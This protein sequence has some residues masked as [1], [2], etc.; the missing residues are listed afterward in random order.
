MQVSHLGNDDAFNNAIAQCHGDLAL[1][2]VNTWVTIG[3]TA[4]FFLLSIVE[5]VFLLRKPTVVRAPAV[6]LISKL[7]T[8]TL[9]AASVIALL[10]LD[11]T[12]Q[13]R[14]TQCSLTLEVLNVLAA[15]SA[16]ILSI[17]AH[18]K[19]HRPPTVL[20]SF[21]FVLLIANVARC[22]ELWLAVRDKPDHTYAAVFATSTVIQL[23][24]LVVNAKLHAGWMDWQ[25]NIHSP[26]ETS[27]IFSLGLY[28]W[29]NQLL[30]KGYKNIL[31]LDDLYPLD[32]TIAANPDGKGIGIRSD[33][34]SKH[35]DWDI[36]MWVVKPLIKPLVLP[37]FPRLCL[38]AFNFCQPFYIQSLLDFITAGSEGS[39]TK[40]SGLI[41]AAIL[42]YTGI[43]VSTSLY[44]Y[45]QERAQSIMRAY[46]VTAIYQKTREI[47][48]TG[49]K[50]AVTLMSTDVDRIYTGM[51]NMHE[52]WVNLIQ[53]ALAC[54]LLQRQLGLAFLAPL[55]LVALSFASSFAL[56]KYAIKYQR[57][58][59]HYIEKR[60]SVTSSVLSHI[61][62]YRISGLITPVRD[63]VQAKRVEEIHHGAKSRSLIASSATLS[64]IPQIVAP[65]V[66][67]S[68]GPRVISNANAYTALSYLSLLTS[69]LM[70]TLQS[71]PIT[72]ACFAC[73]KRIHEFLAI[74]PRLDPRLSDSR[75]LVLDNIT[76]DSMQE[77]PQEAII[78]VRAGQF[79]WNA[80][81]PVLKNI[82]FTLAQSSFMFITGPVAAGKSTLCKA[83]L[84]EVPH[85]KGHILL[86][87]AANKV[88]FC[89]Q[90]PFLV[91]GSVMENITGFSSFDELRYK[92]VIHATLLRD[93]L[94]TFPQG[95]RTKV[96]SKGVSLSGGQRQRISLARA[97]YHDADVLILD[98]IFT[99]LDANTQRNVCQRVFG[100]K[101][102]LRRRKATVVL[103]TQAIQF[104]EVA[105]QVM[106][107][108]SDGTL[109]KRERPSGFMLAESQPP[110]SS[111]SITN[112]DGEEQPRSQLETSS[113]ADLKNTALPNVGDSV[114]ERKGARPATTADFA[115]YRHYISSIGIT[116]FAIYLI[117]V[118]CVGFSNNFPTVWVGL[119]SADSIDPSP[120]RS[121]AFYMGIFGLLAAIALL[122]VFAAGLLVLRLFVR[123][124]GTNLHEQT[125]NTALHSS[126]RFL[127]NTDTGT[128]L[129]LFS[130]DMTIIDSQ[131]PRMIN[132][133][134]FSSATGLGQAIVI[135]ISSAYLA[136]SYPFL[137]AILYVVQKFYLPTSKQLRILDLEAK[138][139]LYTQFLDTLNGLVTIRA[140]GWFPRLA[141]QNKELL[142]TSQRPS[143]LL[144]MAQQWLLLTMNMVVAFLA[145]ILAV[146]ATRLV[147]GAD[148]SSVGAGMV[149]L[150][151][152]GTTLTSMVNSYTGLEISLGGISRLKT[153]SET[154]DRED[155]AGEDV[156]PPEE[157]P[158]RGKITLQNVTASYRDDADSPVISNLSLEIQPGQKVA[159][160][161]RTGSGKSSLVALLLRLI[162][163]LT[164]LPT[165]TSSSSSILID[166]IPLTTVD[167]TTLRSR[168]IAASQDTIFL[169][170]EANTFRNNLDPWGA[171]GSE[172]DI[173]AVLEAVQLSGAVAARGG[174]DAPMGENDL[175]AGQKQLFSLGRAILRRRARARRTSGDLGPTNDDDSGSDSRDGG[176]LLLDEVTA[177]VDRETERI[178]ME[179]VRR[180]FAAYTVIMV[181]HS[182]EAAM[183]CDRVVVMD[184]GRA[185]EDGAPRVLMEREDGEFRALAYAQGA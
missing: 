90:T 46:L 32:Q 129:N 93:D 17:S 73:L 148:A 131:L 103:C 56:S 145:T 112:K 144:A 185:V 181:T 83:L 115:I 35:S 123:L 37:I 6:L 5:I 2:L 182:V 138:S 100:P 150:M 149:M 26:E 88:S 51:R 86:N 104:M 108:S 94:A 61:K 84:G 156:V 12:Q 125:L 179:L 27:S 178:V 49:D 33:P 48:S 66:A 58:W 30:W 127:T 78:A 116:P 152:F 34:G 43:A 4:G 1:S 20:C 52:I 14:Q 109:S 44:W 162:D 155:K 139:P 7:T 124:S 141:A 23:F 36:L 171:A 50:A 92:E 159:L 47:R 105:D 128:I 132:N 18:F 38:V 99:G 107:L 95:D 74:E 25:D 80:S 183:G 174:L 114:S 31:G 85:S 163:P 167:R 75:E 82:N 71:I 55:V 19:S 3:L 168:L 140:Y 175:S 59:M 137:A 24:F 69:P 54:W 119:W 106:E 39:H 13:G 28:S 29:L 177:S 120:S 65:V 10:V 134:C 161:G 136:I 180:E 16:I 64:Q 98:D 153:F 135:A 122:A 63:F 76:S 117:L 42:I 70:I 160:C 147:G 91:N 8:G 68:L 142:D 89:D 72:A 21:L 146:L 154:T 57:N 157:W 53:I 87:V 169:P 113:E 111:T 11:V 166:D 126:L 9:Y 176:V 67:F 15:C 133:M 22:Q 60:I 173:T 143:Y 164:P 184:K 165:E 172:E 41:G 110:S 121:F 101:G 102:L 158:T 79:G 96:G 77:K 81:T 130:Q 118:A 151:T 170:G 45:Y 97:L 40:A 62:E